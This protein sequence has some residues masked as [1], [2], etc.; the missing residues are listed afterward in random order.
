MT[1]GTLHYLVVFYID[2]TGV[3]VPLLGTLP[4]L[5][6]LLNCVRASLLLPKYPVLICVIVFTVLILSI[7]MGSGKVCLSH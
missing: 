3:I 6:I 1:K 5:S 4:Y 7:I 2:I